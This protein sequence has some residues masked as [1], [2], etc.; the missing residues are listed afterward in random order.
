MSVV[1]PAHD[2]AGGH[3]P[4]PRRARGRS[5]I[6]RARGRRRRERMH[7]RDGRGRA[8]L[9]RTGLGR[10]GRAGVEDR[11]ARGRR[12]RGHRVPARVRGCRRGHRRPDAPRTRRR[13][14]ASRAGRSSRRRDW[15]STRRAPRGPCERTTGSG[16]SPTTVGPGTSGRASTHSRA[17][18]AAA[19]RRGRRSSPTTASCSSCSCP[20][21]AC[22]LDGHAFTVRSAQTI[23]AH[24]RRSTRIA[25]GNLELPDELQRASDAA[26]SDRT[27]NLLRRVAVRPRLWPSFAVYAITSTLPKATAQAAHRRSTGAGVGARRHQQ[28]D[29]M[30][31]PPS[32]RLA[33][34][35]SRGVLV[36]MGGFGGKTLIQLASTVV[37]AR[38][39]SPADFGL[40]AMVTAIVGVADLVRDFGLTGAI[41]QAKKLSDRMWMSVMWLSVALGIGL[42]LIIAASAPLIAWL[43]DEE[44]LIPLTLA[45]APDPARQR[46]HDA[47]AG[48]GAARPPVRD[49]REHRRRV[50]AHRRGP[51]HRGRLP[52]LGRLVARRDVG[53]RSGLPARRPVGRVPPEVRTTAHLARSAP[54]RHDRRQPLRRAAA[55][56]RRRRTST[57][58]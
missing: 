2:E 46:P 5:A 22:T 19:S 37:L 48:P 56:L 17:R 26:G 31:A 15:T 43:Y 1:I 18:A 34:T 57:T 54:A 53:R 6:A 11:R 50:H 12:P 13:A 28:G 40:V 58:W 33:H 23:G 41:I 47:H 42:M 24:L 8:L 39:L 4:A 49:P 36:T 14:R 25:R 21:S 51:R 30:T 44:R 45:I 3:R 38:L 32:D 16:S 20:T 9:R 10:R 27:G 29:R 52:R 7:R 35:S 55:Q